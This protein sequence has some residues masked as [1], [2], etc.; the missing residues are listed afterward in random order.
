MGDC[1]PSGATGTG[2][3]IC[4]R[5]PYPPTAG[6]VKRTLRLAE[7]MQRAGLR[8]QLLTDDRPDASRVDALADRGWTT[9]VAED[10]RSPAL[11]RLQQHVLRLPGPRSTGVASALAAAPAA[12]GTFIQAEGVVAASHLTTGQRLPIIFSTHNIETQLARASLTRA[13]GRGAKRVTAAYH[14]HRVAHTEARTATRADA[15]ICVSDAD[16]D[17]FSAHARRIIVAPNGVDDE[18][19]AVEP[20]DATTEDI[21]FF[22]QFTYAPNREGF[23]RFLADGWPV[24]A[25]LRPRCRLLLAGEASDQVPIPHDQSDRVKVLGLVESIADTVARARL[26]IV[27]IWHGGGTRLKVLESLAACRP[28]V[29]TPLGVSGLGFRSGDHGLVAGSAVELAQ[30]V[31]TLLERPDLL[32]TMAESGR[33]LATAYAWRRALGPAE[34]LYRDRADQLR[35]AR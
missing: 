33:R 1:A 32:E 12:P 27:P 4:P 2:L 35:A 13:D 23:D 28:V 14:A 26:T 19:F 20:A 8:V 3:I 29:S 6:G 10:E 34:E 22:G 9:L 21:L 24:L 18:F 5:Y 7:C 17:W 16:A 15:V 30:A 11:R 25:G 31:A